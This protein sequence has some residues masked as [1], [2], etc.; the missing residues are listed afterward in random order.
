MKRVYIVVG[1]AESRKSSTIRALTG[2]GD[3]P[4]VIQIKTSCNETIDVFV[5]HSSLQEKDLTPTDFIKQVEILKNNP[6]NILVALLPKKL[7]FPNADEYISYFRDVG[8]QIASIACLYKTEKK[9]F[10]I[11]NFESIEIF[12]SIHTPANEIAHRIRREWHWL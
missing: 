4:K 2:I 8:W 3:N 6:D 1:K 5:R 9:T 10:S 11:M 12:N 7:R